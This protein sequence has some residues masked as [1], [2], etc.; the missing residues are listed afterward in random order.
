MGNKFF[1]GVDF[2][3]A[4]MAGVCDLKG[5]G[6]PGQLIVLKKLAYPML[7]YLLNS[8]DMV[9]V[10]GAMVNVLRYRLEEEDYS[11]PPEVAVMAIEQRRAVMLLAEE[12]KKLPK[13]L[14]EQ[15]D[16]VVDTPVD[17][18]EK[19]L[20]E[21]KKLL[22][23]AK[24][25]PNAGFVLAM[26]FAELYDLWCDEELGDLHPALYSMLKIGRIVC[27]GSLEKLLDGRELN[28]DET[29]LLC[30]GNEALEV[31]NK[32][33]DDLLMQY[34][35]YRDEDDGEAYEGNGDTWGDGSV[36]SFS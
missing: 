25:E 33:W 2:T 7:E 19:A 16:I 20:A 18:P 32:R 35:E 8:V 30:E 24:A 34:P 14:M 23:L 6:M 15:G 3:R 27:E 26:K 10:D 1:N 36:S 17:S 31:I 28:F 22:E 12:Y 11:I 13:K 21:C 29:W 5:V 4:I 9:P